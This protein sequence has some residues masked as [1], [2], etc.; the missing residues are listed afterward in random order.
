MQGT[1]VYSIMFFCPFAVLGVC[2]GAEKTR[3]DIG[4]GEGVTVKKCQKKKMQKWN[5]IERV[6]SCLSVVDVFTSCTQR[7]WSDV[8]VQKLRLLLDQM[9]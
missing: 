1:V 6:K 5:Y 7:G 8:S 3:V 2:C 4:V 9:V